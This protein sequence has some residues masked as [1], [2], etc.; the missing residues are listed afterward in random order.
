M[1]SCPLANYRVSDKIIVIL[2]SYSSAESSG[3]CHFSRFRFW[4]AD[5]GKNNPHAPGSDTPDDR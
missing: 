5:G 4:L 2:L 1:C 3:F